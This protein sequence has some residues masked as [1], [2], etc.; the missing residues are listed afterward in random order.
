M[1]NQELE[2]ALV[3]LEADRTRSATEKWAAESALLKVY[4]DWLEQHGW[5]VAS[6]AVRAYRPD[7][8]EPVDL[9]VVRDVAEPL[10]GERY[11]RDYP[12]ITLP[13]ELVVM[14]EIQ[15]RSDPRPMASRSGT[16][17]TAANL[18]ESLS[19]Q[20]NTFAFDLAAAGIGA[21]RIEV[22]W[23]HFDELEVEW[24]A[25]QLS[26]LGVAA[27]NLEGALRL[28]FENDRVRTVERSWRSLRW[29]LQRLDAPVRLSILNASEADLLE[30]FENAAR[31]S[32]SGLYRIVNS[33]NHP[34]MDPAGALVLGALARLAP[35][36]QQG[37]LRRIGEVARMKALLFIATSNLD[38][39]E[40]DS[41]LSGASLGRHVILAAPSFILRP[42]HPFEDAP[43]EG[44][45]SYLLA[46]R[47]AAAFSKHW[48]GGG[49]QGRLRDVKLARPTGRS[50]SILAASRGFVEFIGRGDDAH[51]IDGATA[52]PSQ[53]G[54]RSLDL[55]I[56]ASRLTLQLQNIHF[57]LYWGSSSPKAYD[58]PV[59]VAAHLEQGLRRRLQSSNLRVSLTNA[60]FEERPANRSE[61]G[62]LSV[63]LDLALPS[64]FG[65][66]PIQHVERRTIRLGC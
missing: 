33:T 20:R 46:A 16:S 50:R 4:G 21:G 53:A 17:L 15:A 3:S 10:L 44:S 11:E 61:G 54:S 6:R 56:I 49:L 12:D 59:Q 60:S 31:P 47:M 27:D 24:V 25:G 63:D 64:S 2:E 36:R 45:A 34:G 22:H 9:S 48:G 65:G 29:L 41:L 57:R 51:L 62:A 37:L 13:L 28:F 66:P 55:H 18:Q 8:F 58:D 40:D 35:S 43:L 7:G 42:A 23:R 14:D 30:D 52:S 38:P 19:Q 1:L 26:K 5:D 39:C 32:T